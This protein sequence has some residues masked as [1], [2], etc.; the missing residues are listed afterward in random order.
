MLLIIQDQR[1]QQHSPWAQD[2][3]HLTIPTSLQKGDW[4]NLRNRIR[5]HLSPTSFNQI[6]L[7]GDHTSVTTRWT[8]RQEMGID[9][10][11]RHPFV[12]QLGKGTLPQECF[13]HYI[14]QDYHYLRHCKSLVFL[15]LILLFSPTGYG[16]MR[17]RVGRQTGEGRRAKRK[18][19]DE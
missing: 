7:S 2:M 13:E 8:P 12:V 5:I 16:I 1:Y 18:R 11:V 19:A 15:F 17:D 3:A 14:K 9:D 6:Y 10:Q 4:Q